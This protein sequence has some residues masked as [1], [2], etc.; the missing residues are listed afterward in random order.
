TPGNF[1]E[2]NFSI[3]SAVVRM[4]CAIASKAFL[5]KPALES[6]DATLPLLRSD[7]KNSRYAMSYG[8]PPCSKLFWSS[9]AI[10]G[11]SDTDFFTLSAQSV[12]RFL[13]GFLGDVSSENRGV[14]GKNSRSH[15]NAALIS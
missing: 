1:G 3:S 14:F 8:S 10:L 5:F 15:A 6:I 4:R 12:S 11:F 7:A 9:R 2:L 13:S